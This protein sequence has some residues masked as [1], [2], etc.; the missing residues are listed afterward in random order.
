LREETKAG[1]LWQENSENFPA[2]DFPTHQITLFPHGLSFFL[3]GSGCLNL[4]NAPP[5]MA[6]LW[7][8]G[9][10]GFTFHITI[11]I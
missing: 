5:Q 2:A 3:C 10:Q 8:I 4:W 11:W 7:V 1:N 6:R 9:R